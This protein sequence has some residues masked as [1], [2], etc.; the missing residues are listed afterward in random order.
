MSVL[1]N[2]AARL[3]AFV[4]CVLMC[5]SIPNLCA[6]VASEQPSTYADDP[7]ESLRFSAHSMTTSEMIELRDALGVRDASVDYNVIVDGFG[8]GLAPPTEEGWLSMV[9]TTRVLDSI[10][11]SL[12]EL[13]SSF[14]L[15]LLPTFP[16]VGNQRTQ[17]SCS[18]WAAAYYAY[19]F[20]EAADQGWEQAGEGAENQLISPAWT[21]SRS[22]NGRDMGSS[23]D[24]N[25]MVIVNWGAATLA[26]M[27][28]DEYEHLDWGSPD[29]FREAPAH[30][31]AE[32]FTISY[33]GQSTIDQI[34]T[35]VTGGVP[36]TFAIDANQYYPALISDFVITSVEYNSTVLNHA[37]T[38]V[39]FDDSVTGD[40]EIGAFRVVNSWGDSFADSGYYWFTYDAMMELGNSSLAVLNYVTDV[41]DYV[42]SMVLTWHFDPGPSRSASLEV[43]IGSPSAPAQTKVPFFTQDLFASHLYPDFMCL[44]VSE[45][46]HHYDVG[47]EDFYVSVGISQSKG[48]LSSFKVGLHETGFV[49]GSP[50]HSSGQSAAVPVMNP[51]TATN[52]LEYYAH[53]TAAEAMDAAELEFLSAGAAPWVAVDHDSHDGYDSM[54]SGDI[55]HMESSRLQ[56]EVDGP[57]NLSFLWKVSSESSCDVLS[58]SVVDSDFEEV[59]SGDVGWEEVTFAIGPGSHTLLWNYSKDPSADS[60]QDTAWIDSLSV[61][62]PIPAFSLEQSYEVVYDVPLTV[63][64]LDVSNPAGGNVSFWYVWG[65]GA[66]GPGDATAP[67]SAS[68]AYTDMGDYDLVVYMEDCY[69][70]NVSES[71]TVTVV[72]ENQKPEITA[73]EVEPSAQYHEPGSMVWVNMTLRDEEGDDVRLVFDM[74]D[75]DL[76]IVD[77]FGTEPRRPETVSVQHSYAE[78]DEAPYVVMVTA[79]DAVSHSSPGWN[80]ASVDVLVNTAPTASFVAYPMSGDV[81]TLFS[82]DA[83][84]SSDS[85]SAWESIEVRWDWQGDGSWDTE[86]STEKTADHVFAVSGWYEV[87][88]EVR[89]V[90]GLTSSTTVQ[91]EVIGEPIPE[92]PTLLLPVLALIAAFAIMRRRTR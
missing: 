80:T 28:Y 48:Y 53:I 84:W 16:A 65:D 57:A 8:T 88:L 78:G 79:Y 85:E 24:E 3:S 51:C 54:Q 18:A 19:G 10:E 25:M 69:A 50:T 64:P 63:T 29:A 83:S 81:G 86:W 58:F 12:G 9:G 89:D 82:F 60:L 4:M 2:H 35:L 41:A 91:V 75:G 27:P 40:D 5:S 32:V 7:A 70:V 11:H 67:Y 44:D 47:V 61:V 59:A 76:H 33:S 72:D 22:N 66:E 1:P 42:P 77:W 26:M 37:Q 6:D 30:R 55:S 36:V 49:P 71:S 17:P 31:A 62:A 87:T 13:P 46:S 21:Y 20:Q 92:F 15:S 90:N 45:F 39:G 34:K 23:M 52:S 74:G 14:D 56:V 73:L 68:H 43:G 38:I